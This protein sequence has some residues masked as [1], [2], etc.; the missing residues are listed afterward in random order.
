MKIA[1]T[2]FWI[3]GASGGIGAELARELQR[4]GGRIAIS[5]RRR[6]ALDEVAQGRMYVEP[7]DITDRDAVHTAVES[8]RAELGSIDV[9]VLNAGA[10]QQ[11]SV[12]KFDAAAF[13]TQFD[14]NLM[15][16]VHC[17]EALLPTMLADKRGVITGMASVAGYRGLPGSEAYGS[18]K[19]ALINLLESLR[20]SL[21][22]RGIRVQTISPGFVRTDLTARNK[23]PMPFLIDADQAARAIADGIAAEKTEIVFPLPMMLMM[24]AARLV[25]NALWPKL[26]ARTPMARGRS[27]RRN[28]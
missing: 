12:D 14:T 1:G 24:K 4:R 23:F 5:A 16:T 25:P 17:I 26:F 21:G 20:G 7:V 11:V 27:G 28:G 10:W 13:R 19:A 2:T 9:A 3:T 18:S 8:V 15:G 22:P 6:E